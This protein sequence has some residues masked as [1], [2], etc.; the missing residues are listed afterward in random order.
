[1]KSF[2]KWAAIGVGGLVLL[3]IFFGQDKDSQRWGMLGAGLGWMAYAIL[4]KIE[5]GQRETMQLLTRI[6]QQTYE[7]S[8]QSKAY[9]PVWEE[10]L[11]ESR[12]RMSK[13][14]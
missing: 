2:L 1:M 13:P 8:Q 3:S 5:Q 10:L 4:S 14:L 11:E 7:L 9:G 6:E 12:K